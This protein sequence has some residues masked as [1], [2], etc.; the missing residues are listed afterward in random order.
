MIGRFLN[1]ALFDLQCVFESLAQV[2]SPPPADAVRVERVR[3]TYPVTL[4]QF[5]EHVQV[6]GDHVLFAFAFFVD[7]L[8]NGVDLDGQF[9]ETAL[10]RWP[11]V[12]QARGPSLDLRGIRADQSEGSAVERMNA[13]GTVSLLEGFLDL[14]VIVDGFEVPFVDILQTGANVRELL[15]QK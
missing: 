10:Y 7:A 9:D 13:R 15:M 6:V 1:S 4:E 3:V 8:G 11:V 5:D 2:L 14:Y 12:V